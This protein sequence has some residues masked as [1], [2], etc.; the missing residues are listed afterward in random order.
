MRILCQNN[1]VLLERVLELAPRFRFCSLRCAE[2]LL[3]GHSI[4]YDIPC[5]AADWSKILTTAC[6]PPRHEAAFLVD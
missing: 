4:V 6:H 5:A 1:V 2:C 3:L